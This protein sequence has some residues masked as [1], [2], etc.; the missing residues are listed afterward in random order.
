MDCIASVDVVVQVGVIAQL[1]IC[2]LVIERRE[3]A[4]HRYFITF[5]VHQSHS[6]G[7]SRETRA[8]GL[9]ERAAPLGL[10][11]VR[12]ALFQRT[13]CPSMARFRRD[14]YLDSSVRY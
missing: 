10:W 5:S 7:G 4:G 9:E 12:R 1:N 8:I 14:S 6:K 2:L 11:R 3:H 13:L